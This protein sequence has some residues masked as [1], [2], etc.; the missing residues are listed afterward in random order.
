[1]PDPSKC[2]TFFAYQLFAIR[3]HMTWQGDTVR[4]GKDNVFVKTSHV[5]LV[6]FA[7]FF[8]SY[9]FFQ[10]FHIILGNSAGCIWSRVS[11]CVC[12]QTGLKIKSMTQLIKKRLWA[13]MASGLSLFL[14]KFCVQSSITCL[15]RKMWTLDC[16][17]LLWGH[18]TLIDINFRLSFFFW[19]SLEIIKIIQYIKITKQFWKNK[20]LKSRYLRTIVKTNFLIEFKKN[21]ST[22]KSI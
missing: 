16:F 22:E 10:N 4:R 8:S 15:D 3:F 7:L 21:I 12:V 17:L 19:I 14:W 9:S 20:Y 5:I 6:L 13:L 2:R 11:E 1:M 18:V